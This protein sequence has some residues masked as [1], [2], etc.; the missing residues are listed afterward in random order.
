MIYFDQFENDQKT[1]EALD[2]VL[3]FGKLKQA[4]SK[5][6]EFLL[7]FAPIGVAYMNFH[8]VRIQ[9]VHQVKEVLFSS[10]QMLTS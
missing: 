7:E 9:R 8:M 2:L 4:N 6:S 10:S 1:L 3:G 5:L